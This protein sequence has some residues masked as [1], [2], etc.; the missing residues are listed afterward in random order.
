MIFNLDASLFDSES[1]LGVG[2]SI[3]LVRVGRGQ[4]SAMKSLLNSGKI[5][6]LDKTLSHP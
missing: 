1:C 5:L 2:F 3:K 4:V 6:T